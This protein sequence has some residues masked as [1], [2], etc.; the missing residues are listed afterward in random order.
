VEPRSAYSEKLAGLRA[1]LARRDGLLVAYSGG[2]D[3]S[4]LLHAAHA[5]LGARCAGLLADSPSLP[6]AELVDARATAARIGAR[7][8]EV[9]TDEMSDPRYRANAGD[10]CYWC[11]NALFDAMSAWAREHSAWPLAYGEIA[12]DAF[13]VRPGARAARERGVDAPLA[14][15]GFT[16]ADVRRYARE[17]GLSSADKPASACLASRIPVGTAVDAERLA[18]VERAEAAL[19][20]RGYRVVRVRDHHP[21]ARVEFGRDALGRDELVRARAEAR[22]LEGV[23]AAAGYARCEFASYA[24]PLAR[25]SAGT[26]AGS[27]AAATAPGS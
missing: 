9:R 10:R 26:P 6:R 8:V 4:V 15:C 24:S 3:S 23:L 12:D 19:H 5:V 11:K 17:H 16:K 18:R 13:D 2:V 7:L 21:L 20:A 14:A 1:L 27:P 25:V 22:E